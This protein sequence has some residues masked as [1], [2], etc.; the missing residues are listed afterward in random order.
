MGKY[1]TAL[2]LME[3][4]WR[5]ELV[6][7]KARWVE[8]G[9]WDSLQCYA[10]KFILTDA[11][12]LLRLCTGHCAVVDRL[13]KHLCFFG[14]SPRALHEKLGAEGLAAKAGERANCPFWAASASFGPSFD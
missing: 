5:Y 13:E 14:P 8:F 7:L 1:S 11:F 6:G 10:A 4:I 3:S 9:T 12:G 2:A